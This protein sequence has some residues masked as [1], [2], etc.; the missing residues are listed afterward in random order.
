MEEKGLRK[1][2]ISEYQSKE[3][4]F[5]N[6]GEQIG[7]SNL[8]GY[9]NTTKA[10][11]PH[12]PVEMSV[13]TLL[14]LSEIFNVTIDYLLGIEEN[15]K[16]EN[17]AIGKGLGLRDESLERLRNNEGLQKF[18]NYLC[19][20]PAFDE[21]NAS[22][23]R[24]IVAKLIAQDI[25]KRNSKSLN[26]ILHKAHGGYRHASF[27]ERDKEQFKAYLQKELPYKA[28][29]GDTWGFIKENVDD[30]WHLNLRLAFEEIKE[31]KAVYEAFMDTLVDQ[32]LHCLDY[33]YD[34]LGIMG[35]ISGQIMSLLDGYIQYRIDDYHRDF[36]TQAR[37]K[38]REEGKAYE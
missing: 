34:D 21:L 4:K 28:M 25:L 17:K 31:D 5:L 12:A 3:T 15:Q 32:T 19:A 27:I 36:R 1:K 2:D 16:P 8:T 18:M 33:E 22:L 9:L 7:K 35:R 6:E 13:Q 11:K 30:D 29:N 20:A 23:S 38:Q 24:H 14:I 10:D 37:L 26:S